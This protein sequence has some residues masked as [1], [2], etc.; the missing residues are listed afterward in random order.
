[1]PETV[2]NADSL[3]RPVFFDR[4]SLTADDLNAAIAYIRARL[5]RHNR[6]L[7]GAGVACGLAVEGEGWQVR[8]GAGHAVL[9]SGEE[10]HVPGDAAPFDICEAARACLGIPGACPAPLDLNDD[11]ADRMRGGRVDFTAWPVGPVEDLSLGALSISMGAAG[12]PVAAPGIRAL[13]P[14]RGLALAEQTGITLASPAARVVLRLGRSNARASMIV[15]FGA[16]GEVLDRLTMTGPLLQPET[17]TVDGPGITRIEIVA[18]AG[19][20]VLLGVEIPAEARGRVWLAICA[21]ETPSRF[22]PGLPEH[23][24]PVGENIFPSRIC[25]GFD[26]R[27]LCAPPDPGPACEE[28]DA[29]LCGPAH[30]PCPPPVGEDCLVIATLAIGDHG[31]TE[32]DEFSDRRRLLPLGLLGARAACGCAAPEPP[33]EPTPPPPSPTPPPPS[34]APP[35]PTRITVPTVMTAPTRITLPTQITLPTNLTLLTAP[36]ALPT[37]FSLPTLRPTFILQTRGPG[38]I[39]IPGEEVI[40]PAVLEA[41]VTTIPGIGLVRAEALRTAGINTVAEFNERGSEELARIMGVSE[42]RIAGMRDEV[43]ALATGRLR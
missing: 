28:I 35:P 19:E 31:I 36:T 25:E 33:P 12:A 9:P 16:D 8:V 22:L 24:R 15:A 17:L 21:R 32:I 42:V 40:N 2:E 39:L 14:L 13:G 29:I 37:R 3:S 27:I 1:M 43:V 11:G 5:R 34:S 4:Q 7:L 6:H 18:P 26:F 30:P 23:C 38:G 41:D 10:V 20:A